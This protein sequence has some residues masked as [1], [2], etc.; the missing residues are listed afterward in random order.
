MNKQEF[1]ELANKVIDV[2]NVITEVFEDERK[3]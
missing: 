2:A 3:F 1:S